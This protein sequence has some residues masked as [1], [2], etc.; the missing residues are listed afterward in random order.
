[1]DVETLHS[2]LYDDTVMQ[3][4]LSGRPWRP[5]SPGSAASPYAVEGPTDEA[6]CFSVVDL[7]SDELAGDAL[8]WGVDSHNRIAHLGVALRPK[9]HGQGMGNDVVRVLC[10]YGFAL[11]GLRRLQVDTLASNAAMIRAAVTNGF[12]QEGTLRRSAWIHGEFVD[13]VILGLLAD[14]WRRI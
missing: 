9:F 11:R 13:E 2:E 8:L 6:T 5:L 12:V 14:E 10:H 4:L 7:A 1:M 3:S